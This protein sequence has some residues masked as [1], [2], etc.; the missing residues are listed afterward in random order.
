MDLSELT[1]A[2]TNVLK[3]AEQFRTQKIPSSTA[4]GNTANWDIVMRVH[5]PTKNG[6][7]MGSNSLQSVTSETHPIVLENQPGFTEIYLDHSKI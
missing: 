6:W 4:K 3:K 1:N 7:A 5:Q 2:I